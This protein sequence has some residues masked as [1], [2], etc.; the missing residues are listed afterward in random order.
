MINYKKISTTS[1]LSALILTSLLNP[2]TAS[3][4]TTLPQSSTNMDI[5]NGTFSVEVFALD[6]TSGKPA[7]RAYAYTID[8]TY[9]PSLGC[10]SL[11]TDNGGKNNTIWGSNYPCNTNPNTTSTST[12]KTT[13]ELLKEKDS[14]TTLNQLILNPK[15]NL[16]SKTLSITSTTVSI[17]LCN[18]Q[19]N[20][21][22]YDRPTAYEMTNAKKPLALKYKLPALADLSDS[23]IIFSKFGDGKNALPNFISEIDSIKFYSAYN[24]VL[25]E[26]QPQLNPGSLKNFYSTKL[27]LR[28]NKFEICTTYNY[29]FT[30]KLE[31]SIVS[32]LTTKNPPRTFEMNITNANLINYLKVELKAENATFTSLNINKLLTLKYSQKYASDTALMIATKSN[33]PTTNLKINKNYREFQGLELCD[34]FTCLPVKTLEPSDCSTSAEVCLFASFTP[35][36]KTTLIYGYLLQPDGSPAP[37]ANIE[38]SP[39]RGSQYGAELNY[40]Y[41]IKMAKGSSAKIKSDKVIAGIYLD[42]PQYQTWP[43]SAKTHSYYADEN[44]MITM[45]MDIDHYDGIATSCNLNSC[46]PVAYP[47]FYDSNSY[48]IPNQGNSLLIYGISTK[49]RYGTIDDPDPVTLKPGLTLNGKL[50]GRSVPVNDYTGYWDTSNRYYFSP[51]AYL[52]TYDRDGKFINKTMTDSKGN[53]SLTLPNNFS[54]L[55]ICDVNGKCQTVT[56]YDKYYYLTLDSKKAE[57]M[58]PYSFLAPTDR[59]GILKGILYDEKKKKVTSNGKVYLFNDKQKLISTLTTNSKGEFTTPLTFIQ[60]NRIARIQGCAKVGECDYNHIRADEVNNFI[61]EGMNFPFQ[62]V[63]RY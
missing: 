33:L 41:K 55:D 19:G 9:K 4:T 18:E 49:Y 51:G 28:S 47:L 48:T 20:C 22:F 61:N 37:Y 53:Y 44:G 62:V 52:M 3:Q 42:G 25:Y 26:V 32:Y 13:Q 1:I 24:T 57:A 34:D 11:V 40:L 59:L 14:L 50:L 35:V 29:C 36:K 38:L 2:A 6:A 30:T 63:S 8:S 21:A 17:A 10:T 31:E 39:T 60:V 43:E 27:P 12:I 46:Y 5:V 56:T 45:S 23:Q 15:T 16:Y 54:K 58:T 7:K